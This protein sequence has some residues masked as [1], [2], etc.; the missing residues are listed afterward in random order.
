VIAPGLQ[1][2]QLI[3]ND[4]LKQNGNGET[5]VMIILWCMRLCLRY[6]CIIMFIRGK[7]ARGDHFVFG[8]CPL[9]SK[10]IMMFRFKFI[11][12]LSKLF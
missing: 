6:L 9:D 2:L 5:L 3:G 8:K 1:L 12:M 4:R 10:Q 7:R 11:R